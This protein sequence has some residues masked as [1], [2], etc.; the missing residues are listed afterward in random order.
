MSADSESRTNGPQIDWPM[1]PGAQDT[2]NLSPEVL[3]RLEALESNV[4]QIQRETRR[5]RARRRRMLRNARMQQVRNRE[6]VYRA[7]VLA[8]AGVGI[9]GLLA[10][11]FSGATEFAPIFVVGLLF[12]TYAYLHGLPVRR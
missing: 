12:L 11:L 3:E 2:G 6:L 7:V 1:G 4:D 10:S 5:S 8:A 9:V